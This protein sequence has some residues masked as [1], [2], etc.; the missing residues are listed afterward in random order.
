MTKN[1]YNFISICLKCLPWAVFFSTFQ[2]K[3]LIKEQ[4]NDSWVFET[5]WNY[6]AFFWK[7][8]FENI[9]DE[10]T[11]SLIKVCPQ[12]IYIYI[13]EPLSKYFD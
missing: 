8:K 13:F 9:F 3:L 5:Y 11:V 7:K 4:F 12:S 10:S 2:E 1:V 6:V